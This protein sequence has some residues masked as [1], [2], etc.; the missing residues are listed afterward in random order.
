MG[1]NIGFPS[2][3]DIR[4]ITSFFFHSNKK[5]LHAVLHMINLFH[6]FERIN[7]IAIQ[8]LYLLLL[9]SLDFSVFQWWFACPLS[10]PWNHLSYCLRIKRCTLAWVEIQSSQSIQTRESCSKW[11]EPRSISRSYGVIVR[12]RVVL[13]RTV[14]GDWRLYNLS[15]NHLQSQVNGVC[16][17]MML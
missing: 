1:K 11:F 10:S 2:W 6:F 5:K 12:V 17:S 3:V 7:K 14:V 8:N 15:G 9:M 4:V 16:Q 13:K